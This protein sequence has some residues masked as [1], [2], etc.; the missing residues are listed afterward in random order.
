MTGLNQNW[1]IFFSML[2]IALLGCTLWYFRV[3]ILYFI[4]AVV[5]SF[6]AEPIAELCKRIRYK[7]WLLPA[8]ARAVLALCTIGGALVAMFALF[9]PIIHE[10]ATI[11]GQLDLRLVLKKM[12]LEQWMETYQHADISQMIQQEIS[13]GIQVSSL[14]SAFSGIVAWIGNLFIGVFAVLFI[15]FFFLKD[16]F[17][18]TRIVFSLTPEKHMDAMKN[19]MEHTHH[20]LRRYFI[21]VAIQSLIMAAMIGIS[22]YFLGVKNAL[23]IGLFA[24]LVNVIPYLGPLIGAL[25]AIVIAATTALQSN[26]GVDIIPVVWQVGVVF[27]VAQQIDGFLVQPLILGNSVKAHPL[28]VF[29][30]VLM[31][32]MVGGIGGMIAAIPVYTI[33]R[34]IAREFFS[35]FKPIK[36]L[37]R[38]L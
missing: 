19:I 29:V 35:A 24:G 20:L 22:L 34:V 6:I 17:L 26:A 1:K 11:I 30:V 3:I 7:N 33:I 4:C 8:W 18:F 28:E 27:V 32:G 9:A 14:Q 15:A 36:S 23:L 25:F 10:E 2:G 38:D 31:S 12:G 13:N 5:L 37:T 21:G 16:G